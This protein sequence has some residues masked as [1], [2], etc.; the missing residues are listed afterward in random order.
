MALAA[1]PPDNHG[2]DRHQATPDQAP[3]QPSRSNRHAPNVLLVVW[4]DPRVPAWEPFGGP[5]AMPALRR[6]AD[7]GLRYGDRL[8][9]GQS[10]TTS[11]RLL[12][13][14]DSWPGGPGPRPGSADDAW[15]GDIPPECG[16]IA[17]ILADA[18]YRTYRV[19]ACHVTRQP[20][21]LRES[22][23]C[24][25]PPS[26]GYERVYLAYDHGAVDPPESAMDGHDRSA[27]LIDKAIEFLRGARLHTPDRPWLLHVALAGSRS[28]S[29]EVGRLIDHLETSEQLVDTIVV[30]VG[31]CPGRIGHR[32]IFAWPRE[33]RT[34][35]GGVR[36]QHCRVVDVVPT[37][38]D[39]CGLEPPAVI[40]G[41]AQAPLHGRS[42]RSTFAD[43]SVTTSPEPP[44]GAWLGARGEAREPAWEAG[45]R[46]GA[47]AHCDAQTP[48]AG[49]AEA[50]DLIATRG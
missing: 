17:E 6:I 16:T 5:I 42:L 34:E 36:R 49:R 41:H 48:V 19:S 43:P 31:T 12:T 33:M 18:G 22:L 50:A 25:Q 3:P 30:V 27:D 9:I 7:L 45:P 2:R 24:L 8:T 1:P 14:R 47:G 21:R 37:I 38:L 32:L 40:R 28:A 35:A 39:C 46:P 29:R 13:G 23:A 44:G 10:S 26:R 4:D 20:H 15:S 11:F